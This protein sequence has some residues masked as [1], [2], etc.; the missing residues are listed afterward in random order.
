MART[1]VY[2][3]ADPR[4]G[5]SGEC[6]VAAACAGAGGGT[7]R[8]AVFLF[9]HPPSSIRAPYKRPSPLHDAF[10]ALPAMVCLQLRTYLCA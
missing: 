5:N 6:R 8:G 1:N 10:L 7:P 9:Y 3:Q 2:L 4:E